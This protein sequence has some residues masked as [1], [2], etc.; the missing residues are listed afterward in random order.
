MKYIKTYEFN[1]IQYKIGEYYTVEQ[2][3]NNWYPA[4]L[5]DILSVP[6][7]KKIFGKKIFKF[8][9]LDNGEFKSKI[10]AEY[11]IGRKLLK[12][13]IEKFEMGKATSK[14]NL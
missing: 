14:Y 9:I 4:Q 2:R 6:F 10:V 7:G 11:Y 5:I 12:E 8:L 3:G 1:N 13:E